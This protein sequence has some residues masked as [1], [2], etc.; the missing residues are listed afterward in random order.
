MI[1]YN[2]PIYKILVSDIGIFEATI[3]RIG[4]TIQPDICTV[5][6]SMISWDY[7]PPWP[8]HY[9]S[10]PIDMKQEKEL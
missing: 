4:V 10:A 1:L 9:S 2:W 7:A 6:N 8:C 3:Q 5:K